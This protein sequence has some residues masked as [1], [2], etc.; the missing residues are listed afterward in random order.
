M[1]RVSEVA[2]VDFIDTSTPYAK[3]ALRMELR[4]GFREKHGHEW[5]EYWEESAYAA[6]IDSG[7]CLDA[8][9]ESPAGGFSREA[10]PRSIDEEED[11]ILSPMMTSGMRTGE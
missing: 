6:A 3:H 4:K 10:L 11:F 8:P 1:T 2:T 5:G 7:Y 9:E